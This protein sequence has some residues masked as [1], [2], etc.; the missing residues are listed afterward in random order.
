MAI[1]T[2]ESVSGFIATDPQH[3]VTETGK[4]RFYA[5]LGQQ[6]FRREDDG[7]FTELEPTYDNLAAYGPTAERALARLRKGDSF[8]AEGYVR[9]YTTQRDGQDVE[10]Q[11]FVATKIGHDLARTS[12]EVDRTRRSGRTP[13]RDV[14]AF[15]GPADPARRRE[16]PSRTSVL[17][18]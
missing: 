12:Y 16:A 3:S 6:R 8:V 11:E 17:G 2:K 15:P 18:R 5:R 1:Q 4:T 7:S 14:P 13:E 10:R 9:K